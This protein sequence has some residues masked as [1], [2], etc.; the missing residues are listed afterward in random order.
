MAQ[1]QYFLGAWELVLR[2]GK[3]MLKSI[4]PW[5][6]SAIGGQPSAEG[7]V[8][9]LKDV[10]LPLRNLSAYLHAMEDWS[11]SQLGAQASKLTARQ[12]DIFLAFGGR[13]LEAEQEEVL[14]LH[15]YW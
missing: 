11:V 8:P 4:H 15:R 12:I 5:W 1:S 3:L 14:P 2:A 6:L 7:A 9:A 10:V 13:I